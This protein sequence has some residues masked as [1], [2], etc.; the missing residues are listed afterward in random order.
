MIP[1]ACQGILALQGRKG[2][3]Y[4]FLDAFLDPCAQ[5]EAECERAFVTE[6]DGG[7]SSPIAA[8]ACRE[9]DQ[10]V[11][12]GL[13]YDEETGEV[14]IGKA[15][16]PAAGIGESRALGRALAGDLRRRSM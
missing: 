16:I 4:A 9:G 10:L 5:M 14:R 8:H 15:A 1:A 13:Y 11:L 3:D 6:L 2:E 12:R 7:C